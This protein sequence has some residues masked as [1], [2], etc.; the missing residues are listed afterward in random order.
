MEVVK[1][2]MTTSF[3]VR[4]QAL[5]GSEYE[6]GCLLDCR[7]IASYGLI[8]NELSKGALSYTIKRKL[9]SEI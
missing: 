2:A 6:N 3:Q 8:A 5:M 7:I 1:K 4:S 9:G